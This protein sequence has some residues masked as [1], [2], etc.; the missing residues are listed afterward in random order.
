MSDITITESNQ[1]GDGGDTYGAWSLAWLG[2][3]P[4]IRTL[5]YLEIM[6]R[7]YTGS[8]YI[9]RGFL[10]FDLSALTGVLINTAQVKLYCTYKFMVT[11]M[12]VWVTEGKHNYPLDIV[13][14]QNYGIVQSA[15]GVATYAMIA[16]GTWTTITL[17][18]SGIAYIQSKLGNM[19]YLG[20]RTNNDALNDEN[21]G[22]RWDVMFSSGRAANN[23]PQLVLGYSR[24]TRS[25]VHIIG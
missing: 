16:V 18:A 24:L 22:N 17:N 1:D 8:Y 19:C 3:T 9:N 14:Y 21:V 11:A 20:L 12:E 7:L 4:S 6:S 2:A 25:Q 10:G 15:Y 23:Q 5:T 13:D